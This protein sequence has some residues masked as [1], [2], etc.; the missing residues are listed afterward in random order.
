MDLGFMEVG[1]DSCIK[2]GQAIC[3][4]TGRILSVIQLTVLSDTEIAVNILDARF[5]VTDGHTLWHT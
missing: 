3:V 1:V 4:D 5:N 2:P